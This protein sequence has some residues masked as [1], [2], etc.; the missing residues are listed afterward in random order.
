MVFLLQ[1]YY[2]SIF[3]ISIN[4]TCN[5]THFNVGPI[6]SNMKGQEYI[7][8]ISSSDPNSLQISPP[9]MS[10]ATSTFF[11][12]RLTFTNTTIHQGSESIDNIFPLDT[13]LHHISASSTSFAMSILN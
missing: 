8:C 2:P 3:R 12:I 7:E 9:K 5:I 11:N 13:T 6:A 4:V 10:L 1:S